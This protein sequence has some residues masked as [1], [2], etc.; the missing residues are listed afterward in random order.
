[1]TVHV[2]VHVEG[3]NELTG[4]AD[5][6]T[7]DVCNKA[8][9]ATLEFR[10]VTDAAVSVVLTGHKLV[11]ELNT[12]Y[13]DHDYN[14]DVL[15]F[16]LSEADDTL[17]GEVYVD[18]ETAAERCGEF[19]TSVLE[20]I[21]RYVVHGVL[22]LTGLDDSTKEERQNMARLEDEILSTVLPTSS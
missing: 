13:L 4:H 3:Q 21:V 8:A 12:Q 10:Q 9:V 14:T 11:H 18:V 16:L 2:E 20:E 7:A 17:E 19:H 1:M 5:T 6:V 15:S 22:H